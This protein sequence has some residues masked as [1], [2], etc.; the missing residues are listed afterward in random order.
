MHAQRSS[1]WYRIRR[2]VAR[3]RFRV[4]A[5]AIAGIAVLAAGSVLLW[6]QHVAGEDAARADTV[7]QFV[8]SIIAQADPVAS[9]ET[10]DA[11]LTLLTTAESRL[12]RE[13][14]TNPS[15]ALELRLAI[16]QAYRNRGEFD[17]TRA[18]LRSAIDEARKTLPRDDLNLMRAW[19]R[20]AD[21]QVIDHEE[22]MRELDATIDRARPLGR[23]GAQI[24]VEGLTA[25]AA[26][27]QQRKGLFDEGRADIREAHEVAVRFFGP[28]DPI[29]LDAALQMTE[30]GFSPSESLPVIEASYQSANANPDLD[31]AHPKADPHSVDLRN[32]PLSDRARSRRAGVASRFRGD[33]PQTPWKQ[34]ADRI[35]PRDPAGRASHNGRC[36]WF[37]RS[38]EGSA[39]ACLCARGARRP[40][41]W[42]SNP[43]VHSNGDRGPERR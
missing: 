14:G 10:R 13:L 3:H 19:V 41:S 1:G 23:R 11:D 33:R 34:P 37:T 26:L 16:A 8:L 20:I 21:W 2:F 36:A 12:A 4:V 24:L 43:D 5:G 32:P 27:R 7:K 29:A 30:R 40:Q 39:G 31:P 38:R 18:T 6:Q 17:R 22:V 25:R 28:G 9:R 42:D 35:R 15:L